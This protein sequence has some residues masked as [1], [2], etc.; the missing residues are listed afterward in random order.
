MNVDSSKL[1]TRTLILG[2]ISATLYLL[3]YLFSDTIL[4][5]SRQGHWYF[6]APITIAFVFSLVHGSF[7]GHFWDLLGIK[8]KTVK[9]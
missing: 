2:S 8:A 3:L 5:W 4:A 9:K 7:T 6:I 1:L